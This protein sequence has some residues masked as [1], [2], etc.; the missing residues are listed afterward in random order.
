MAGENAPKE[1]QAVADEPGA[2]SPDIIII[3]AGLAGLTAAHYLTANGIRNFKILE[4]RNRIGGRIMTITLGTQRIE[5]GANWIHGVLG[6]P[7]YEYALANKLVDITID[8]KPHNVIASTEQ[9]KKIPITVLQEVYE[10]YFWFYKKCEDY[11][12]SK[13]RPTTESVGQKMEADIAN[14]LSGFSASEAAVRKMIFVHLLNRETCISGCDS[15]DEIDLADFGAYSE[16]PGGNLTIPL[17]FSSILNSLISNLKTE[18]CILKDHPV[19]RIRWK[20]SDGTVEVECENGEIYHSK[21]VIVT[22]PLGVLKAKHE[23]LFEPALPDDKIHAIEKLGFGIVDKIFLEYERPFLHPD[24][25][26]VINLWNP[27][28]NDNDVGKSWFKK[29]Y[30]FMKI[31][32]TLYL[33]W[34]SGREA[35]HAESITAEEIADV[36]TNILRQFLNDPYVPKPIRVVRTRWLSEPYTRGSYTSIRTG[37]KQSDIENLAKPIYVHPSDTKVCTKPTLLF[38]GEATHPTFFS[39]TH[40]AFVSGKCAAELLLDSSK[41]CVS[42]VDSQ[43]S[44]M[45]SSWVEGLSLN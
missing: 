42:N 5:L 29:I 26:E 10:Q 9:G 45:M 24:I 11:F 37:S 44:E 2:N 12:V 41:G 38:A 25:S 4:A 7:I 27:I 30:S 20:L 33:A 17:G 36:C 13:Q 40:G 1:K 3:G 21:H 32:D 43:N 34:L 8:K 39:T 35:E 14:Y 15:M 28:E 16:L 19:S 22:I 18:E 31:S 6:N 23:Q